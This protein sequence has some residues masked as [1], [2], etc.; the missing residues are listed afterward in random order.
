MPSTVPE[1]VPSEVPSWITPLSVS[2]TGS[3]EKMFAA[4]V[5]VMV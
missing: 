2:F 5:L 1:R 3:P 4:Y